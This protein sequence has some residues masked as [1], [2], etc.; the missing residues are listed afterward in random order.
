[1]ARR[2]KALNPRVLTVA[3]F[4]AQIAYPWYRAS[5]VLAQQPAWWGAPHH[6]PAGSTWK[7]WNLSIPAAAEAW[8]QGCVDVT[9]SGLVDS[10]FV[11]GS[12]AGGGAAPGQWRAYGPIA[13][14]QAR[15]APHIIPPRTPPT[16]RR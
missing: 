12:G 2:I 15:L 10:C 11:D 14:L 8:K 1:M 3:Y 4:N 16:W 9:R 7:T 13:E 6:G 5:R